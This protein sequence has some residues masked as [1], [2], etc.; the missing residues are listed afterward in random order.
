V[1]RGRGRSRCS[2]RP[3]RGLVVRGRL[4]SRSRPFWYRNTLLGGSPISDS[5]QST[6]VL[7]CLLLVCYVSLAFLLLLS[8]S[9]LVSSVLNAA[10]HLD[11]SRNLWPAYHTLCSDP[12][13]P[14]HLLHGCHQGGIHHP[15]GMP[16]R[17]KP[18]NCQSINHS[19][20]RSHSSLFLLD[21][22]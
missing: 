15:P 19:G 7:D 16:R 11:C 20:R 22:V 5:D 9:S 14:G 12:S 17:P 2:L 18:P 6:G 8:A 3:C 4:H 1:L 21:V 10:E 13:T